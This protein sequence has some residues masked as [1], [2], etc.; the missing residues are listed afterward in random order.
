MLIK[1]FVSLIMFIYGCALNKKIYTPKDI[2]KKGSSAIKV[3]MKNGSLYVLNSWNV[4]ENKRIL[5][6]NGTYYSIDRKNSNVNN[7]EIPIDSIAIIESNEVVP[8]GAIAPLVLIT[9]VSVALTAYCL[10][11]EK[12]CFGSCPTFY[13]NNHLIAEGFSSS[14]APPLEEDDIDMLYNVKPENGELSI[15]M[16]NEALETHVVRY[17]NVLAVPKEEGSYIFATS[18]FKF[19]KVNKLISPIHAKC[20]QK[21]CLNLISSLDGKEW[22]DLADD[23]DLGRQEEIEVIFLAEKDKN[24]GLVIGKRQTLLP[25]FLFY[26]ILAYMGNNAGYFISRIGNENNSNGKY[27]KLKEIVRKIKGIEIYIDN[28]KIDYM[29]SEGPLAIDYSLAMLGKLNKDT[30]KIKLRFT[31]GAVRLDYVALAEIKGIAE[32][33]T[34]EP[35]LVLN[36]NQEDKEALTSLLDK[37]KVLTTLPGDEYILKYKIPSGNFEFFL[38]TRGYYLEWIRKEWIKEENL[39]ALWEFITFPEITLKKLAPKY[40][41][42]E[43]QMEEVFWRSKYVKP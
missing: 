26:Q 20:P 30:I 21:E 2:N 13:I 6:G 8:S 3:H 1:I 34:I 7:F 9:S 16:K 43:P 5:K 25:T 4:D 38:H 19:Y 41:K 31:K 35:F 32:P 33:I 17:A 12:A 18:D 37:N 29:D 40:K 11:N 23:K 24:Y 36:N 27:E 28:N 14:I 39:L 10:S 15:K 42:I 22:F